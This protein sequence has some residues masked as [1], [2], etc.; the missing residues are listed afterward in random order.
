[1]L[2]GFML[3]YNGCGPLLS[4]KKT[5]VPPSSGEQKAGDNK[6]AG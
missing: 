6:V 1:M 3:D 4:M 2:D 5:E